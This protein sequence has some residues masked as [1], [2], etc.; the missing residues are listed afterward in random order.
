MPIIVRG[1]GLLFSGLVFV[2]G[3]VFYSIFPPTQTLPLPAG[4]PMSTATASAASPT[5]SLSPAKTPDVL[6]PSD[7]P[8]GSQQPVQP[9]TE[10][11]PLPTV[12]QVTLEPSFL[13]LPTVKSPPLPPLPSVPDLGRGCYQVEVTPNTPT[14]IAGCVRFGEGT[15]SFYQPLG[16]GAAMNFCTW[17]FR[18]NHGCGTVKVTS[19]QTGISVRIPVVDFCDCY[20]TTADER[21]IDL[22][23]GVLSALGLNPLDGLYTVRVER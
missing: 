3:A 8:I 20:T 15:A 13:P 22:Q 2:A 4:S 1:L 6:R 16:L 9:T 10:P 14:G 23:G 11:L 17:T 21:I 19:L 5:A 12:P 7:S 18:H